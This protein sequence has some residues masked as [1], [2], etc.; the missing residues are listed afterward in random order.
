MES[1]PCVM[2]VQQNISVTAPN[3]LTRIAGH[4]KIEEK[5]GELSYRKNCSLSSKKMLATILTTFAF[6]LFLMVYQTVQVSE[7]QKYEQ[8][9]KVGHSEPF[10]ED[11][12]KENCSQHLCPPTEERHGSIL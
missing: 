6:Q 4:Q 2:E 10:K 12:G 8:Q 7:S 11:S 1:S 9:P 3:G 5:M